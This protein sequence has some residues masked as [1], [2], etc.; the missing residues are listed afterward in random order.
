MAYMYHADRRN[1]LRKGAMAGTALVAGASGAIGHPVTKGDIDILKF[2][3]EAELIETDLWEQ[4]N[5]LGGIR[6]KEE[7]SGSGNKAYTKAL[8]NLDADMDQYIHDNTDDERSHASF[9]NA[10]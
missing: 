1:F 8:S 9:I 2:L 4:Y 7:P 10:I 5:E 3:E 6:D